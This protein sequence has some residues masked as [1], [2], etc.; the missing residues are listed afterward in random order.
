M[1]KE[2][3]KDFKL[4]KIRT[5]TYKELDN[6]ISAL[7]KKQPHLKGCISYNVIMGML[8][9]KRKIKLSKK[10]YLIEVKK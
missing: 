8:L 1:Q 2:Q 4:I 7:E 6:L 3:Q 10:K 9:Q 5:E